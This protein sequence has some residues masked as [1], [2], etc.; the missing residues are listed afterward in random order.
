MLNYKDNKYIIILHHA[1]TQKE[2]TD[3]GFIIIGE[4]FKKVPSK[5]KI[6]LSGILGYKYQND[7]ADLINSAMRNRQKYDS[8]TFYTGVKYDM[9]K[10]PKSFFVK[11]DP[12]IKKVA[13]VNLNPKFNPMPNFNSRQT[14]YEEICKLI[15]SRILKRDPNTINWSTIYDSYPLKEILKK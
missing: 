7:T 9:I 4:P 8:S 3:Y 13:T 15:S 1:I 6:E 12:R 2:R 10:I 5:S 14:E 11:K